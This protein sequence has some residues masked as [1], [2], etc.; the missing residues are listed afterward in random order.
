MG[1]WVTQVGPL[2]AGQMALPG[3]PVALPNYFES[4]PA[5]KRA[6]GP[7]CTP[8]W[9]FMLFLEILFSRRAAGHI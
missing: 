7:A 1:A 2:Q 5:C 3:G 4:Y 8:V 6:I 9:F